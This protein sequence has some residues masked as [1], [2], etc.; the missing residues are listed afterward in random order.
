MKLVKKTSCKKNYGL[1]NLEGAENLK[2]IKR[3]I[4]HN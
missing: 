4:W 3:G 1:W 2:K